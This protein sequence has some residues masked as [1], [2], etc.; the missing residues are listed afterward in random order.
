MKCP[1]CGGNMTRGIVQ[2][3]RQIFF[4]TKAHKNWFLPDTATGDEITLSSHN[5]TSP[6]CAAYHCS[7]CKKVVI[8]YSAN[9]DT[10]QIDQ[11]V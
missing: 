7:A 9:I 1:C 2:S 10:F 4:T 5:W 3:A 6:T 11:G 8:D